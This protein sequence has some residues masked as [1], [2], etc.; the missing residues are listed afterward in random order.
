MQSAS[1]LESC[2][3]FLAG[4][5]QTWYCVLTAFCQVADKFDLS[6]QLIMSTWITLIKMVSARLFRCKVTLFSLCNEKNLWGGIMKFIIFH[7]TFY[8]FIFISAWT[9]VF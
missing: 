6:Y 8:L 4:I 3:V 5:S 7:Q 9:Y 2:C 1:W